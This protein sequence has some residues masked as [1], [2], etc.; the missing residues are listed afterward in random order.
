MT[1]MPL[2]IVGAALE[3]SAE[4]MHFKCRNKRIVELALNQN[5]HL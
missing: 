5:F 4:F 3:A 2:E 1:L